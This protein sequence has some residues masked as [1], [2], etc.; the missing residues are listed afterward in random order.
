MFSLFSSGKQHKT[1]PFA[2]DMHSHLLPGLDDGVKTFEEAKETILKLME[3]GYRQAITTPHIMNDSYRNTPQ[4]IQTRLHELTNYLQQEKV[5]FPLQAAAEY[6]LDEALMQRL[7]Q[8]ETLLTFSRYLLFETNYLTEP[9]VLR[10]FIFKATTRGYKLI[11][12]H[13][14]RYHFMTMEKAEDLLDRGVLMQVNLLSLSGFYGKPVQRMAE[15]MIDKGWIH[16]AGTDC[17][18]P[19]QARELKACLRTRSY[20]K[21]VDLPLLNHQLL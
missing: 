20:K 7:E 9:Y 12:A 10:D 13:P 5:D 4:E 1:V 21:L 2:T 17:H 18:N 14:E 19:L 16:F 6:Y 11:L 15:K 3:W 8:N